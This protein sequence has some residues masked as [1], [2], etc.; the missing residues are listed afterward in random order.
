MVMGHPCCERVGLRAPCCYNNAAIKP[1]HYILFLL[2]LLWGCPPPP[3]LDV[4]APPGAVA[5]RITSTPEGAL[6]AV[7]GISYTATPVEVP[8]APGVHHLHVTRSGYFPLD[9][10][11]TVPPAGGSFNATLAASH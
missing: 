1:I 10:P 11:V 4:K 6:V 2:C 7:D 3:R 8:L 9:A 5:F